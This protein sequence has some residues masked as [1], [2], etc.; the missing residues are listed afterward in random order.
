[1]GLITVILTL[2]NKITDGAHDKYHMYDTIPSY[3]LV[4][5][6]FLT[7]IIFVAGCIKTI[8]QSKDNRIKQF[9]YEILILGGLYI[10]SVPLV[11]LSV[12]YLP[13][14]ARKEWV[15]FLIELAK[16]FII[17]LLAYMISYKKSGYRSVALGDQSF[18]QVGN[19]IL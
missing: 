1:M 12:E 3:L 7:I 6:K 13:P 17:F 14:S 2:L 19:R 16:T 8:I 15:F 10:S 18:M 4:F 9:M 11:M 5:F